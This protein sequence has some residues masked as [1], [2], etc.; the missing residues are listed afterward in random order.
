[1]VRVSMQGFSASLGTGRISAAEMRSVQNARPERA[2][3]R[4]TP[5]PSVNYL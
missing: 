2:N 4:A 5:S 3:R 1:M